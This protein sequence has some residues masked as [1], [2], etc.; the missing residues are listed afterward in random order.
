MV[1]QAIKRGQAM[2]I[3]HTATDVDQPKKKVVLRCKGHKLSVT[4]SGERSK[5]ER[6]STGYCLCG[7]SESGSNQDIVRLEYRQHLKDVKAREAKSGESL[8]RP[9]I[10]ASVSGWYSRMGRG[11]TTDSLIVLTA[12]LS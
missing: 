1:F 11:L 2:R 3:Q 10:V 6:S 12:G 5:Q 8:I 7:W 9:P 4:W